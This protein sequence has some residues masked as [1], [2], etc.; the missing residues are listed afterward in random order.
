MSLLENNP[1]IG[2]KEL[3]K[4]TGVSANALRSSKNR[5]RLPV[6]ELGVIGN[7]ILFDRPQAVAYAKALKVKQAGIEAR[8][9]KRLG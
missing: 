4:V 1:V 6:A 9:I 8:R 5:G 7:T 2:F 3:S